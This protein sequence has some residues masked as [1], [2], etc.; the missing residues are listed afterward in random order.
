MKDWCSSHSHLIVAGRA[1]SIPK[2]ISLHLLSS[3]FHRARNECQQS[4]LLEQEQPRSSLCLSGTRPRNEIISPRVSLHAFH[5][6]GRRRYMVTIPPWR[7]FQVR[8]GWRSPRLKEPGNRL[9]ESHECASFPRQNRAPVYTLTAILGLWYRK[10]MRPTGSD[11]HLSELP[12]EF[13]FTSTRFSDF[14][15]FSAILR[16]PS[17]LQRSSRSIS[18][19][20]FIS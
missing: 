11:W 15:R 9:H 16:F 12:A 6:D 19:I 14:L 7:I 10:R 20:S 17:H 1:V 5:N 18:I 3:S 2:A 4:L 13:P 8:P